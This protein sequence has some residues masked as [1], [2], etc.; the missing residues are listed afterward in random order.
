MQLK[1]HSD[2]ITH[3]DNE[4]DKPFLKSK[5][6][7]VNMRLFKTSLEY[8]T[9]ILQ[10][11][12]YLKMLVLTKMDGYKKPHG[13]SAANAGLTFN[14]ITICINRGKKEEYAQV[15][16]NPRIV[17]KS[18][19]TILTSS[20]CGSIVLKEPIKVRRSTNIE[21]HYFNE[22]GIELKEEFYRQNGAFT[23]QHE[24]DHNNGVLITDIASKD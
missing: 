10:Q 23:I 16:I 9:I 19:E 1:K 13:M 21:V 24:V 11:C 2:Y 14:I 20:N 6:L 5:L 15:M 12:E 3:I 4:E 17:H 7:N 18:K 8:K 22:L